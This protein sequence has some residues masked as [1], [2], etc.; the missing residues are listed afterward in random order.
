LFSFTS[1]KCIS[2]FKGFLERLNKQGQTLSGETKTSL[3]SLDSDF[4]PCKRVL[5]HTPVKT[6]IICRLNVNLMLINEEAFGFPFT[7]LHCFC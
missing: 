5:K 6:S 7:L 2:Q 4:T 3:K 1:L